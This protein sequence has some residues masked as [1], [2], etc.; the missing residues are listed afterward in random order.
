MQVKEKENVAEE[1]ML[2][3]D[4]MADFAKDIEKGLKVSQTSMNRE[5]GI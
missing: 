5:I 4:S 2:R 1:L 3:R